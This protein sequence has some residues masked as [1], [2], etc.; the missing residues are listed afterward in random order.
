M[1]RRHARSHQSWQSDEGSVVA[2]VV[3]LVVALFVLLGL[4]LD[5]GSAMT[6]RQSAAVEAEQAARAG[7]GAL[8][9]DALRA[10]SVQINAQAAVAA[11]VAFTVAAGHRGSATVSGGV[12]S[13]SV[14]YRVPTSILGMV[15][16]NSLPISA[17]ASAIDVHGVTEGTP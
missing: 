9:V 13:V 1:P 16:I 12:V 2:F 7:A 10:G 6:A 17:S 14:S 11:A 5:G 15:G 8:S 4:V 3:L